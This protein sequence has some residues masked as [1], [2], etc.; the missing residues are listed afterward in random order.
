MASAPQADRPPGPAGDRAPSARRGPTTPCTTTP[1]ACWPHGQHGDPD[2]RSRRRAAR[3]GDAGLRLG[4]SHRS[5]GCWSSAPSTSPPPSP[6]VGQLPRLPRDGVRRP[7]GV[8]D[9]QPLP[10]GRRGRRRLAAPLPRRPRSRPVASTSAPCLAVLTHDPKF[11]VPLLE[12]ALRLP[13]DP[14]RLRRRH[15]LAAH[16]RRPAGPAPRGRPHR[17]RARAA[18]LARSGSTS[19][20]AHRRRP[21]SPSPPRSSPGAG[22]APASGWPAPRVG[23][24]TT[25]GDDHL[26]RKGT[27]VFPYPDPVTSSPSWG[28]GPTRST[29]CSAPCRAC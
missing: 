5:H 3:R 11:D 10:G 6:R 13:E 9:D 22:A 1:S 7:A 21:R 20:P 4:A 27:C 28:R 26:D 16:P 2:L 19:A 29:H 25:W 12:V 24:I 18:L 23:S 15:G 8:R 17:R 14:A